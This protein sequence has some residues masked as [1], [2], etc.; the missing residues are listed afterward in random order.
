MPTW[1]L[2][3]TWSS[4][5][6]KFV[7]RTDEGV[8]SAEPTLGFRPIA[9]GCNMAVRRTALDAIGPFDDRF[10]YCED[11]ELSWRLQEA[12][13]TFA[14]APRAVVYKRASTGWHLW[15]QKYRWS[16][17]EP[18]LFAAFRGAGMPRSSVT[19]A[20]AA[21]GA[22]VLRCPCFSCRTGGSVGFVARRSESAA[23]SDQCAS[24]PSTY[25]NR[26]SI[27]RSVVRAPVR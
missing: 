16:T 1:S 8:I 22:L 13:F 17:H 25:D 24:G 4:S 5:D 21:W 19:Q 26:G 15:R 11:A 20:L 6:S 3:A 18:V 23:S 12:G 14:V 7:G 27:T 9:I 10:K 2:A